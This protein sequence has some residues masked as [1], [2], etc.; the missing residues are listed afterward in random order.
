MRQRSASTAANKSLYSQNSAGACKVS[1]PK[2]TPKSTPKKKYS[3]SNGQS[4]FPSITLP[5][6]PSEAVKR[7]KGSR[8]HTNPKSPQDKY[9]SIRVTKVPSSR[10]SVVDL[11]QDMS[12]Q[13]R[14]DTSNAVKPFERARLPIRSHDA[15]F[16]QYN[17]VVC[18]ACH[19]E[20]PQGACPLKVAGVE[21][22]GLC[23]LAH[24]GVGRTCPHIKSETQ[25][26]EM[27]LALKSSPESKELIDLATKYLR[28]VKG[29]LVQAKKKEKEKAMG[30]II[31]PGGVPIGNMAAANMERPP[32]GAMCIP[33][34][35]QPQPARPMQP[36]NQGFQSTNAG[37][38]HNAGANYPAQQAAHAANNTNGGHQPGTW[39]QSLQVPA[40]DDHHVESALRGFLGRSG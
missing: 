9:G 25:V 38:S 36:A 12:E 13:K 16:E 20:H 32:T 40:M 6:S 30:A 17:L 26:R 27:L 1:S 21:H 4:V 19:K 10:Q 33:G 34:A 7:K 8:R 14:T 3:K 22:C 24:Y 29:T 15:V 37:Y 35:G 18:P 31:G 23:G 28:G 39:M 5:S 2:S 11:T